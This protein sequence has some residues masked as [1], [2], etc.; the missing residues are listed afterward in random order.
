M[1]C[2]NI[3]SSRFSMRAGRRE[4]V[5]QPATRR[6]KPI[7][8]SAW[9]SSSEPPSV[10]NQ[11]PANCATTRREK[12][13]S[14]GKRVS[15]HSVIENAAFLRTLTTLGHRSYARECGL[16]PLLFNV[17]FSFPGGVEVWR[18]GLGAAYRFPTLSFVGASLAGPCFRFH[19]PL[20]EP[21]VRNDRI[22]LSEKVSRCRP[23]KA[24]GP[25]GETD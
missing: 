23:R 17:L 15:L 16:F 19:T 20:I 10:V 25:F 12:C 13:A 7:L 2:A 24:A 1:R 8:R 4:S 14:N 6:S 11:S 21:D 22:R 5:K 18:G 9:R 3:S